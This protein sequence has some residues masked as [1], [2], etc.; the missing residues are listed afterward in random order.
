MLHW[1]FVQLGNITLGR[2]FLVRIVEGNKLS[3]MCLIGVFHRRNNLKICIFKHLP[4]LYFQKLMLLFL[5]NINF[6]S[7]K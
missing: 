7:K 6:D 5:T 2:I 4:I 1:Y 3:T